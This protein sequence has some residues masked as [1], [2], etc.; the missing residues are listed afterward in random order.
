MSDGAIAITV[1]TGTNYWPKPIAVGYCIGG[2]AYC[3][4]KGYTPP[5]PS[6]SDKCAEINPSRHRLPTPAKLSNNNVEFILL[7]VCVVIECFVFSQTIANFV[8][9]MRDTL[10]TNK[11]DHCFSLS[12]LHT[13]LKFIYLLAHLTSGV[14]ALARLAGVK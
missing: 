11:G 4:G 6:C 14:S 5:S 8:D 7:R 10:F 2:R 3:V 9:V 1:A 13:C 12:L